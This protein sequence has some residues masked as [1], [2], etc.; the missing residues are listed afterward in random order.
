MKQL[1]VEKIRKAMDTPVFMKDAFASE[2]GVLNEALVRFISKDKNEPEWL[3]QKRLKALELYNKTPMP[4][5]GPDLSKLDMDQIIFYRKPNAAQSDDWEK[6]PAQIKKTF[7][8]LG[9]PEA[10]RK[11]LAGAGAQYESNVVYHKLKKEFE[12]MGVIFEDMDVAVQKYPE[13]I[14]KY[15]M[16]N[17]IPI[18]DHKFI[19]LHAAVWSGGTF[20]YIP[21]D[22]KVKPPLQAYFRMNAKRGGQFEHTLIV[23]E[24]GSEVNYIEGCSAPQYGEE[25]ALHA[26]GVEIYV[27]ENARVR[28]SSVEN[29]STS[30]FNLNTKRAVVDRNGIIEWIGG[31]MGSC[32]TML[33]PC[34]ILKGEGSKAYHL[35]IAYAGKGQNQDTGAKVFHIAKRT[36]SIIKMKSISKD[37]G[38]CTY[39]GLVKIAKGAKN[40]KVAAVCDALIMDKQSISNTIPNMDVNEDSVE[41]SHEA[42]VGK[43]SKEKIFYLMSRG[44]SEE[45]AIQMIV[46]GFIEPIMKE[47]PL[48]YA[49]ELNKLIQLEMTGA[50]G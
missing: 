13:L 2:P 26:G 49:V 43:L 5:W 47:L 17:C 44:I 16:T 15:F 36:S 38:V 24:S 20:I 31:N 4:G 6:V 30:T 11:A 14:K 21:K 35:G 50:V 27:H 22:V 19:M 41:I 3:L 32:T 39:R 28:Y 25:K 1:Q 48:E 46:S 23:A 37:G 18:N 42:T 12:D 40:S 8:A 7:D 10:E 33:Y 29:W 45:D 9:I 34:S